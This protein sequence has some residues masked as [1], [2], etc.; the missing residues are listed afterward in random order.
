MAKKISSSVGK[1][2][3]N[4]PA[5]TQTVQQLL[6]DFSKKC[7]F[8]KLDVDGLVGPKTN[9][10][11]GAVQ[12]K[13]IGMAK[14]D[15]RVDPR[16]KTLATLNLGP[17]K[18]AA[19]EKKKNDKEQADQQ[20]AQAAASGKK[21]DAA[22]DKKKPP[23][24][25]QVK[26]D[27]RGIDKRLLGI[28]EAVSSHYNKPIVV[29]LGRAMPAS[30]ETL[31]EHWTGRMKRGNAEPTLK[32]DSKLRDELDTMYERLQKDQFMAAASKK[33]GKPGKPDLHASGRAIDLPKSTDNR[34]LAA[35]ATMLKG[36]KEG[37][38]VHFDDG[39]KSLPKSIPEEVK[40]KW[41]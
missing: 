33:L 22:G 41:K 36:K 21:G 34:V 20:Q 25:P 30:A 2:G 37:D 29:Q 39:G 7:G 35:L 26:G 4:K 38:V 18:A 6:N 40:K 28:L 19:A 17:K 31:W 14:A 8:K 1:G 3:K 15:C 23:T 32:S 24:R 9:A 16:G 13:A 5:D 12:K 11:I 10:A 27:I